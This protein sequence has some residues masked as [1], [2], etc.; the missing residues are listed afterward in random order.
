MVISHPVLFALLNSQIPVKA[1]IIFFIR[2]VQG[3]DPLVAE[4]M[5]SFPVIALASLMARSMASPPPT[6]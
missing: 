4:I 2:F 3:I 6:P 5:F 1:D